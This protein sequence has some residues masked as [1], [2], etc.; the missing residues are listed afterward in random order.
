MKSPTQSREELTKELDAKFGLSI[1][2][3]SIFPGREVDLELIADFI[4]DREEKLKRVLMEARRYMKHDSDCQ[5]SI[6][7]NN[8]LIS[9]M[10]CSCGMA[11]SISKIDSVIGKLE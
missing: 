1:R 8:R 4:I 9:E 10:I 2:S 6:T 7:I 3:K 5:I 11:K